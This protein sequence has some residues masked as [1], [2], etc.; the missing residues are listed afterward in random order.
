MMRIE[1]V[2]RPGTVRV[3]RRTAPE[4]GRHATADADT[5]RALV[6]L[7]GGRVGGGEGDARQDRAPRTGGRPLAEFVAHLIVSADQSL[8][9]SRIERTRAAAA[10]YA[11]TDRRLA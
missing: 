2:G 8:R 4:T 11:E 6:V 9:P 1:T 7:P 3:G 5:A 10:L